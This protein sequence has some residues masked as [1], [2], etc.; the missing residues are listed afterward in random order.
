M[1]NIKQLTMKTTMTANDFFAKYEEEKYDLC[2]NICD[3]FIEQCRMQNPTANHMAG[4]DWLS[5]LINDYNVVMHDTGD[6]FLVPR[7]L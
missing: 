7:V 6:I 3:H 2:K 1:Y 4:S 5:M